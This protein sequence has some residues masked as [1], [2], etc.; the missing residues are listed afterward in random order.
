MT[1]GESMAIM[2]AVLLSK[3]SIL[4]NSFFSKPGTVNHF[5]EAP[6]SVLL[7]TLPPLPLTHTILSSTGLRPRRDVLVP[8]VSICT[9]CACSA[10][11]MKSG[12]K[13]E[14][15]YFIQNVLTGR[16]VV[17]AGAV[18]LLIFE[19]TGNLFPRTN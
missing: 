9:V 19:D 1:A 14:I 18:N 15:K 5:Q 13:K 8:A 12:I 3:A 16:I 2:I 7:P 4:R 10:H 17:I 11:V 6:P